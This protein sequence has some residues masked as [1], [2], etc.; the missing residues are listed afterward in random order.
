MVSDYD[1][2]VLL[3]LIGI[4]ALSGFMVFIF[5][6]RKQL[7]SEKQLRGLRWLANLRV[8]MAHIQQHR[9][10]THGYLNG[11]YEAA[12][13]IESLQK[14]VSQNF[15]EI[16]AIDNAIEDNEFWQGITQHWARLAGRYKYI[17]R[18]NNLMQHN[19]LI[20]NILCFIDELA[21]E[22]DLLSLKNQHNKPLHLYWRDLLAA[23]EF[24][25][26]ARAIGTGV[27]AAGACDQLSRTR[28]HHLCQQIEEHTNRLWSEMELDES[29]SVEIKR[30]MI[31]ID[32]QILLG[33]PTIS[34]NDYFLLATAAI[35]S[36]LGQFDLLFTDQHWQ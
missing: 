24:I 23:V 28:L 22:C 3:M 9:G 21:Q 17:D 27:A 36:L 34:A 29:G 5:K 2:M 33:M 12:K 26:R 20:K 18:E 15:A 6:N 30:L 14:R 25:G 35:D 13:E 4:A 10:M 31:C 16:S 8:V 11:N 7:R 32:E 19:Q 1:T